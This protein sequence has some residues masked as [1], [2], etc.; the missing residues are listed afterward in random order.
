MRGVIAALVVV[1]VS[2][3]GCQ[4]V[5]TVL[6]GM[7][8]AAGHDRSSVSQMQEEARATCYSDYGCEYGSK[9]VKAP[10]RADGYCA[11]AVDA[12]G[13]PTFAGPDSQSVMPGGEGQC[14]F[15]VDCPIAF[16]CAIEPGSLRGACL[17]RY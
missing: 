1:S 3:L 15:D 13:I 9:C 8:G 12:Y 16:R 11:R 17:T 5:A 2:H 10:Y 4:F 14:T 6:Q 7:G